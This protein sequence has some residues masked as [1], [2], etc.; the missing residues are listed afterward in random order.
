[1]GSEFAQ[2][3]EWNHDISLDWHLLE[4]PE[5]QGIKQLVADLNQL[6]RTT[7]AL[8]RQ[9][10]EPDG[11][12]WIDCHDHTQSV[13]SYLRRGDSPED[14]AVVVCN[15]TPLIRRDYRVGVPFGGLWRTIL[16]TDSLF[17]GGSNVG[18]DEVRA[19][20]GQ[21]WHGFNYA[22]SL[23]LPPLATLVLRPEEK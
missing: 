15:F 6:Y 18:P 1:M 9:D 22:V 19:D 10:C 23:T 8:H 7:P 17:Y 5:N 16:N 3:R 11:F 21:D 14:V 2:E 12:A 20:E 13:L 4:R